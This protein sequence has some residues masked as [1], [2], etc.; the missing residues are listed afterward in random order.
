MK[1]RWIPAIVVVTLVAASL[2]ASAAPDRAARPYREVT[3]P[4]GTVIPVTL[5][6]YVATDTS[7]VESPVRAHVRR[8]IVV[9][10]I[11][12]VPAGS[13]LVG[14]VT[15]AERGGRVKGDASLA[16]RFDQ[17]TPTNTGRAIGIRTSSVYRE[18]RS[19]KAK[20]ARTIAIPA[21]GGAVVGAIVGGK[22]GA[23]IG[24]AAGAGGGTAVAMS[25]RG[26]EVRLGP[27]AAASVRLLAPVTIR[28]QS[29]NGR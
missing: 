14:H 26:P 9:N 5:D 16:F 21:A 4:A 7:R 8:A 1:A 22:K 17:L 28:V 2:G 25:M 23:A 10:G 29:T 18:A 20:D 15:H 13:R 6:S 27:G 24:A 11:T 3:L 12:V 19:T